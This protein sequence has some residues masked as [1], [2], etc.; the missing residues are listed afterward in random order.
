MSLSQGNYLAVIKVFGVGGGGVNA[1]N[2]MISSGLRSVEFLAANT[3]AQALLMSEAD[4]KAMYA[5]IRSLG[6]AGV[7]MPVDLPPGEMP[8]TP[9]LEAVPVM[10][11]P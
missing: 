4:L 2:R 7:A 6:P 9:Y 10:P 8:T 1:I 5:Y 11:K 3:D